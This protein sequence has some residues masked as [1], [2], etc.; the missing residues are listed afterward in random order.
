MNLLKLQYEEK[1]KSDRS[2]GSSNRKRKA[3]L[4]NLQ[5]GKRGK[6]GK[7]PKPGASNKQMAK[8][9]P[10]YLGGFDLRKCYLH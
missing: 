2:V 8:G 7:R 9:T 10:D 6:I 4:E 5:G 3:K 1:L